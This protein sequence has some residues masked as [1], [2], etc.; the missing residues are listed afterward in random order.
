MASSENQQPPELGKLLSRMGDGDEKNQSIDWRR[1]A[2]FR[3]IDAD[4]VVD[5]ADHGVK[6]LPAHDSQ[7]IVDRARTVSVSSLSNWP[8]TQHRWVER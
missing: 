7:T 6:L 5:T 3:N 4:A 2:A 8:G 1:R